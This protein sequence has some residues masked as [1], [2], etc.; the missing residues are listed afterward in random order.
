MG[1]HSIYFDKETDDKISKMESGVLGKVCKKAIDEWDEEINDPEAMIRELASLRTQRLELKDKYDTILK[2]KQ[3]AE[4]RIVKEA[5]EKK[6]IREKMLLISKVYPEDT[7]EWIEECLELYIKN[8]KKENV[9]QFLIQ[10]R[11][12]LHIDENISKG[13]EL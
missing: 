2:R 3:E 9:S 11:R 10:R 5:E 8:G 13:I 6:V 12:Q 1:S 4:V 7:P